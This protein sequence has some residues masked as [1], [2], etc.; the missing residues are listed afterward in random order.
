MLNFQSL[1]IF[2]EGLS[3]VTN[4]KWKL[5]VFGR[6]YIITAQLIIIFSSSSSKEVRGLH[7]KVVLHQIFR[8][9]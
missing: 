6:L 1:K 8:L 7:T 5:D 2:H 9:F 3:D 4:K